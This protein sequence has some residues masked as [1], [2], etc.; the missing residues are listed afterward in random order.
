[1][2][3]D[4]ERD[5]KV[6]IYFCMC[7]CVPR[8]KTH[9]MLLFLDPCALSCTFYSRCDKRKR[10]QHFPNTYINVLSAQALTTPWEQYFHRA[11]FTDEETKAWTF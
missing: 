8:K 6:T 2:T 1:M 3:T 11:P 7:V 10:A 9:A 5:E 4:L